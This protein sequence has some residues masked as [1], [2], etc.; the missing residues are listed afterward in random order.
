MFLGVFGLVV[1]FVGPNLLRNRKADRL[2]AIETYGF[3]RARASAA[4]GTQRRGDQRVDRLDGRA[5]MEGRESTTKTM[6]LLVRADLPWRA[7]EWLVMRLVAVVVVIAGGVL[8]LGSHAARRRPSS[9]LV[10]GLVAPPFVLRFL[11]KRRA[12]KFES[13]LPDVMMLV[14]TSL[15]SGFS[16]LQALD[17]VAKDAPEPAAKEFSRALAEARIGSDV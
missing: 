15:A 14:A 4:P 2:E 7:G 5:L 16:L 13:V 6:E 1:A 12:R 17:S 3:G 11:A 10:L 9:A 8:L